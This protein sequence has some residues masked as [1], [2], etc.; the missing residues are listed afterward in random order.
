MSFLEEA[1]ERNLARDRLGDQITEDT[2]PQEEKKET[3]TMRGEQEGY[4]AIDYCDMTSVASEHFRRFR[5]KLKKIID[6]HSNTV[7]AFTSSV[8]NE[9]RTFFSINLA[10]ILA[11]NNDGKILV[12][13]TDFE[14]NKLNGSIDLKSDQGFAELISGK[15]RIEDVLLD[16]PITGLSFLPAGDHQQVNAN[17]INFENMKQVMKDL[18]KQFDIIIMIVPPI[19]EVPEAVS[20]SFIS[21]G[22]ILVIDESSTKKKLVKRSLELLGKSNLLGF[23]LNKSEEPDTDYYRKKDRS[24]ISA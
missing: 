15:C 9:G 7:L 17:S 5:F 14:A 19:L 12:V 4:S 20:L 8:S 21:D 2:C 16:G 3:C 10:M 24:K 1:L 18:R 6:M 22:V 11:E 23:V 13:D